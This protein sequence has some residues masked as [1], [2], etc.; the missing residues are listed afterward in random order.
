MTG[1]DLQHVKPSQKSERKYL[2]DHYVLMLQLL[3]DNSVFVSVVLAIVCVIV[4]V[5][6]CLIRS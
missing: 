2:G 5:L 6:P 1:F 3:S 4:L